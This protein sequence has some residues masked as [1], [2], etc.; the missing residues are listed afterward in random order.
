MSSLSASLPL[1]EKLDLCSLSTS[2]TVLCSKKNVLVSHVNDH[3]VV[4]GFVL[5]ERLPALPV[6]E[7]VDLCSFLTPH[8]R[9]NGWIDHTGRTG[10][11]SSSVC[12]PTPPHRSTLCKGTARVKRFFHTLA[13]TISLIS[14]FRTLQS[15]PSMSS[16]WQAARNG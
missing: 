2:P 8:P 14:A 5:V 7:Q 3:G 15:S 16:A 1:T 11:P 4:V 6:I 12:L 9:P 10:S 13:G